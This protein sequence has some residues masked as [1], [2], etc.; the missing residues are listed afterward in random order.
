MM[1]EEILKTVEAVLGKDV[2]I[3]DCQKTKSVQE[4]E[5]LLINGQPVKL[6]GKD[7]AAIKKALMTGQIPPC[8]LLNQILFRAGILRQPVRLET[9]LSVKSS[10]TTTEEIR[11]ARN[12]CILDERSLETKEDNFYTSSCSEVWEPI[13]KVSSVRTT[14][15]AVDENCLPTAG[16]DNNL[17]YVKRKKSSSS[18]QIPPMR[19]NSVCTNDSIY[20]SSASSS[21]R[22]TSDL[23]VNIS[24][25]DMNLYDNIQSYLIN[26]HGHANN[27]IVD[28]STKLNQSLSCDSGHHDYSLTSTTVNDDEYAIPST[29]TQSSIT[30]QSS[31]N[32]KTANNSTASI[33]EVDFQRCRVKDL[34]TIVKLKPQHHLPTIFGTVAS[35]QS[36]KDISS[37]R[38]LPQT[39]SG[40]QVI[41]ST[42]ESSVKDFESDENTLIYRDGNLLSASLEALIQHMVPTNDYYPDRSYLFAFLLSSRLF[43]KPYQLL[44]KIWDLSQQQ[45]NLKSFIQQ[46]LAHNNPKLSR[47][48]QYLIQLLAEWTDTFPYDFR[49]ERL[50]TQIRDITQI[51][52]QINPSLRSDV[53]QLLQNLLS[54]L[55]S[56]EKYEEY[57]EKLNQKTSG[58]DEVDANE[59]S[60]NGLQQ[61][62]SVH[63][64]HSHKSNSSNSSSIVSTLTHQ[65]DISEMCSSPLI[66]A[67]QLTHIELERLSH[68]GPEEFVQAFTKEHPS[69]ETSFKDLKKTRNLESYVTWFNRLSYLVAT[70][71][72]KHQKKKQRARIIEFWIET[73]R[74]SFN[75]GNF[76]SLMAIIAGLNMSPISRLKKTWAKIQSAK[77]SILEHQMDS[78]SN[79]SSYRSTLKA[80]MWRSAG[81][82]DERERIVIPFFSLLVKDLYFLNEGCSNKL[83]NGHINFEKFW[84]LAKQVTEFIAWKQVTCPFEK[85]EKLIHYLQTT[86]ILNENTLALASFECEPPDNNHEKDH[87]K[88]L[89]N[90]YQK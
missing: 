21:S 61:Q 16:D 2:E 73:A 48:T 52:I 64:N 54:K 34:P 27:N 36:P 87:Y 80:A 29:T 63:S 22:P 59:K 67:H 17:E 30:T 23:S 71:V 19:Q 62:I 68:I 10:L 1:D 43:I 40:H 13:G 65:T 32:G 77:F 33:D 51:S 83:P 49:D 76:N 28:N 90:E 74:E 6:E 53:S 41:S 37:R 15:C 39:V 88:F 44:S 70:D 5:V 35:D 69:I 89:K 50:M 7:A 26:H 82:T 57:M 79:F 78:S 84:Q 9:S 38:G 75:I 25:S 46:K 11:V 12:G 85:N 66:L 45:Q 3:V 60:T 86:S 31:L 58:G 42:S 56:L 4:E 24:S 55:Q 8:D 20:S 72:I 18:T 47:F 81:A 14:N